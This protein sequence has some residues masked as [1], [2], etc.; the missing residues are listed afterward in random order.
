V[1]RQNVR[2]AP[3]FTLSSSSSSSYAVAGID[4]CACMLDEPLHFGQVTIA[5]GVHELLLEWRG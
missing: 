4:V 5:S 1:I 3:K 2:N